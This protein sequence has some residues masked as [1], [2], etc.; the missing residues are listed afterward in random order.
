M[1]AIALVLDGWSREA[2]AEACAMDR[3]T[4]RDWVHRYNA[5]GLDGLF[6]LPRRNGPVPRLSE[7]QQAKVEQWVEQGPELE[8]DGVV[9][10]RCADPAKACHAIRAHDELSRSFCDH[11]GEQCALAWRSAVPPAAA[12]RDPA[13]MS[14]TCSSHR[15][16]TECGALP[17]DLYI[18]PAPWPRAGRPIKQ[19]I[20]GWTITNDWPNRIPVGNAEL[21]CSKRGS[22][23]SSTDCSGHHSC[24]AKSSIGLS[25][26][27]PMTHPL[28]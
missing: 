26:R 14:Q 18:V 2:A 9:R 10:W 25:Y 7:E 11:I 27:L 3:Q 24:N 15:R 12:S 20:E 19:D 22:A 1:L 28:D 6:N 8:R 5:A 4:L 23:I 21:T 13:A 16:R 17:D